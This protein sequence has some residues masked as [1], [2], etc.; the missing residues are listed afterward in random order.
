M[1]FW[2]FF[3][4]LDLTKYPAKLLNGDFSLLNKTAFNIQIW[5]KTK[6]R[7]KKTHTEK[8]IEP[9]LSHPS[10]PQ[11][12]CSPFLEAW[13]LSGHQ[14][15]YSP[16]FRGCL[17]QPALH[18]LYLSS[19]SHSLC[20]FAHASFWAVSVFELYQFFNFFT[21]YHAYFTSL[22]FSLGRPVR[23]LLGSLDQAS[24]FLM[25]PEHFWAFLCR[26]GTGKTS[27]YCYTP[28]IPSR[29]FQFICLVWT[30]GL[31]PLFPGLN[32]SGPQSSAQCLFFIILWGG[33]FI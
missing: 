7:K 20:N 3:P 22:I 19:A 32:V 17:H 16:Q 29:S 23:R 8:T 6:N 1:D 11:V 27:L 18:Q 30:R 26:N 5:K 10:N 12:S 15:N 2:V 21:L 33:G 28:S 13:C 31:L 9:S 25:H 14:Q 24:T 4:P